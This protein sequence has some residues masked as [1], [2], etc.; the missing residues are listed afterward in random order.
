[1]GQAE[2]AL[3][4]AAADVDVAVNEAVDSLRGCARPV[5]WSTS[6]PLTRISYRVKA[7]RE[8]T[9]K[10]TGIVALRDQQL[11]SLPPTLFELGASVKSL[12]ATG[13][14]L[15]SLP[16]ELSALTAV[17]RVVL[18]QNALTALPVTLCALNTLKLLVLDGN[19]LTQLPSELGQLS[20][21][22]KLSVAG[23]K[24]MKLPASLG[25][26]ASL[27]SLTVSGNAL[28]SLPDTLGSCACLEEVDAS[29]NALTGLPAALGKL[30]RLTYLQLDGN[31]IS[32]LPGEVL[33][34]CTSLATLSLHDNPIN[35]TAME[36]VPGW[37]DMEARIQGKNAKRVAGGVLLGDKGLDDGLDHALTRVVVPHT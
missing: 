24:L 35:I 17:Q 8:K 29:R 18:S 6:H 22:E 16:D 20:K 32:T 13:N 30:T 5:S 31:R 1:M 33:Q 36:Q 25:S 21:L 10:A 14:R 23:N 7:A 27:K 34:G 3:R 19:A 15:S 9:W 2:S 12:D 37:L 11:R 4:D 28:T 26:L